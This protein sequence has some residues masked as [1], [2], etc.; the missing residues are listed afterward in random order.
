MQITFNLPHVFY[1]GASKVDNAY[2][3]R[4]LLDTLVNLN[5]AY[6]RTHKPPG[7]YQSGV[8]YGRTRIWEPIPALFLANKQRESL[9]NPFWIPMGDRGGDK[10]G[11]CKSLATARIAE[12]QHQGIEAKPVF[13]FAKRDKN[14]PDSPLDF[15][16]LV[17][18]DRKISKTGWED[19]SRILGMGKEEVERFGPI[20]DFLALAG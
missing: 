7:L 13:R 10:K 8:R 18:V 1:P 6:L 19:P 4:V 2:A 20:V 3:L 15:H 5:L 14:A 12:L 11:D 16:I 17:Q 9:F